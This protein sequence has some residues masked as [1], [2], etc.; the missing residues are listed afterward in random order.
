LTYGSNFHGARECMTDVYLL[1]F[2][3]CMG[4]DNFVDI[5]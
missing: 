2:D 1:K 5:M 4:A 3:T